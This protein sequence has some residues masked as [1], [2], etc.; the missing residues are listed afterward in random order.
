MTHITRIA[1]YKSS[2]PLGRRWRYRHRCETCGA[3]G[4][5]RDDIRDAEFDQREHEREVGA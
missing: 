2:T 4:R 1:S 3:K 5:E